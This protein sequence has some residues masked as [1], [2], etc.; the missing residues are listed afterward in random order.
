MGDE[1]P[2]Q[3]KIATLLV[4]GGLVRPGHKLVMFVDSTLTGHDSWASRWRTSSHPGGVEIVHLWGKSI[5]DF[6]R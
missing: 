4:K 2:L 6:A 5:P 1:T 3:G